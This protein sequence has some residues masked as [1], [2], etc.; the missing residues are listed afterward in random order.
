MSS[1][2]LT[3]CV[4]VH[5]RKI[6]VHTAGESTASMVQTVSVTV[7]QR[8]ATARKLLGHAHQFAHLVSG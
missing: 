3:K 1:G 2:V 4:H 7:T 5:G 6:A 8:L